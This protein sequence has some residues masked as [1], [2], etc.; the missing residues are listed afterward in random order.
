MA[1]ASLEHVNI[2]TDGAEETAQMLCAVFGWR[3]R[4][5]GPAK[6]GG[7][8]IHVGSETSYVA[9]YTPPPGAPDA[10]KLD[11]R[12]NHLG[13]VVDDLDAAERRVMAAGLEP[14]SHGDYAP[15]RR[16]YFD[17]RAGVEIEVVSYA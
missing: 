13:V 10:M 17:T 12:Y 7:V 6:G 1:G 4:W 8:S 14:Y 16:F 5:Q 11:G 2:T 15:G 9:L 3:I